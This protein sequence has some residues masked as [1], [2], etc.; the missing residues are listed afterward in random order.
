MRLHNFKKRGLILQSKK[1]QTCLR[2]VLK[3]LV[4]YVVQQIQFDVPCTHINQTENKI[5][6]NLTENLKW[7]AQG[8]RHRTLAKKRDCPYS[9]CLSLKRAVPIF[10]NIFYINKQ[11]HIGSLRSFLPRVQ[12]RTS[13]KW[14][15]SIT[16][17][18]VKNVKV[19]WIIADTCIEHVLAAE[20]DVKCSLINSNLILAKLRNS[21]NLSNNQN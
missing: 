19:F 20:A 10:Q 15:K 6:V 5:K 2:F 14:F 8:T 4:G 11:N 16:N 1:V 9:A 3:L 21:N 17:K 12:S 7:S 18:L 13:Y